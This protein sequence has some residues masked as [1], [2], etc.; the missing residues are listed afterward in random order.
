MGRARRAVLARGRGCVG[1]GWGDG[2]AVFDV[3]GGGGGGE[4]EG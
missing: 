2:G 1:A 3:W 4:G